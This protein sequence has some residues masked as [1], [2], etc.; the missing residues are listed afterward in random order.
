VVGNI[1]KAELDEE[2]LLETNA[3]DMFCNSSIVY[4]TES[5]LEM[6]IMMLSVCKYLHTYWKR[7]NGVGMK[8][9]YYSSD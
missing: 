9:N 7:G 6:Q 4:H 5:I 2:R 8:S 1:R 3:M